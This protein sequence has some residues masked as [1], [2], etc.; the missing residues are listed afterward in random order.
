MLK[1]LG[2]K[3]LFCVVLAR[4]SFYLSSSCLLKWFSSR[5]LPINWARINPRSKYSFVSSL[6]PNNDYKILSFFLFWY[7]GF[8]VCFWYRFINISQF[9]IAM[10]IKYC[11]IFSSH[12]LSILQSRNWFSSNS[13]LWSLLKGKAPK[14][15]KH[16]LLLKLMFLVLIIG[17][18]S[19][20]PS[21]F[22]PGFF[23]GANFPS[24]KSIEAL[25]ISIEGNEDFHTQAN[26][27][28]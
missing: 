22:S 26:A 7:R 2:S 5:F 15:N 20:E 21:L 14:T 28:L 4:Y 17:I 10:L 6:F 11:L 3:I 9:S 12:V 16:L 18:I 1:N 8:M 13:I 23:Q 27:Q 25:F 24:T 19:V